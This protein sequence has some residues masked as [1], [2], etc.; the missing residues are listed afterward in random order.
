MQLKDKTKLTIHVDVI[1][2][3][4]QDYIGMGFSLFISVS[5]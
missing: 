1:Y 4:L 3:H 5:L 2:I